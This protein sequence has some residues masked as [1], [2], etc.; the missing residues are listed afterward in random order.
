MGLWQPGGFRSL[1]MAWAILGGA[2]GLTPVQ[3][4]L[5]TPLAPEPRWRSLDVY[6]RTLTAAEFTTLLAERYA[7]EKAFARYLSFDGEGVT[8]FS[9]ERQTERLWRLEF[10]VGFADRRPRPE[11][12]SLARLKPVEDRPLAGLKVCLDPGHIGG[13]WAQMEERS[14]QLEGDPPVE[15]AQLNIWAGQHAARLLKEA[16]AEVVWTKQ[17]FQPV[18]TLRPKDLRGEALRAAFLQEGGR[19]WP[20]NPILMERRWQGRAEALFYRTAEIRARAERVRSLAPDLTLCLHFNA[21]AW[22]GQPEV[23]GLVPQSRLVVFVAGQYSAEELA[24]DDQKFDLLRK[25]LAREEEVELTLANTLAE[26]MAR[27][28]SMPPETYKNWPA[29][30]RVGPNPYVY[31]RNLLAN[32]LFPGPVVFVEGPYMNARDAYPRLIAG[33]FPGLQII[34]GQLVRSIFLDYGE[35]L[36]ESVKEFAR[37]HGQK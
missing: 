28:W 35:I 13:E 8:I 27:R 18:T 20:L 34:E 26:G 12:G 31:A 10:A 21:A 25:L 33:D 19:P 37:Q 2:L 3:A 32:R 30:R 6:Q 29:V 9:D 23:S 16:G 14:F 1:W 15:E 5:L 7:P 4:G 11:G 36:A 22:P 17:D 24:A